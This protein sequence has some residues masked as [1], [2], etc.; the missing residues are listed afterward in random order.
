[1]KF[2]LSFIGLIALILVV[3]S[4]LF[5]LEDDLYI[6]G[7]NQ[8]EFVY[9]STED[10]LK[11][12]FEEEFKFDLSYGDFRFGMEFEGYFPRYNKFNPIYELNSDDIQSR[13]RSRFVEYQT[14]NF[15]A[16]GGTFDAVFGSGLVLHAY[17]NKLMYEDNRLEGLY[18][19][20]DFKNSHIKALYST[21]VSQ[22]YSD[23]HDIVSGININFNLLSNLTLGSS[24]LSERYY[25]DGP[26]YE[27]NER[28]VLSGDINL[29]N[30]IF[31]WKTEVAGSKKIHTVS[32]NNVEGHAVYSNLNLYLGKFT[33]TSAYKNYENFDDRF[34][35][36]PTVNYSEEPL[37]E[38]GDYSLVGRDEEGIMGKVRFIPNYNN[39][40]VV[41]YSEGWSSD[42]D[43]RQSDLH[44]A[45][46]RDFESFYLSLEFNHLEMI[47]DNN[48]HWKKEVTPKA[49]VD[50][51]LG[52]NPVLL[53][54]EYEI[55]ETD[56]AG[57][58]ETRYTP[59]L[60]AELG[61][62]S[63]SLSL[64]ASTRYK[65]DESII[66]SSPRVGMELFAPIWSHTNVKFFLG[67]EKG[68]K[69]CR[70]GVCNYQSPFSGVRLTLTTR[71]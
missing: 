46:N 26:E 68:G 59:M 51:L 38:V 49:S 14:D 67:E 25:V 41:N 61:Y 70:N 35:E 31:G 29:S 21:A 43:V 55:K 27:Y 56:I 52:E 13:W 19:K 2:K 24:F 53:K 33:I 62:N 32:G 71:F 54:A 36:P 34:S 30:D 63:Y 8:S 42:F 44:T 47:N 57:E 10:S 12:Y 58:Q 22:N 66:D 50:F 60:Q 11:S 39:E 1:M 37:A 3:W 17:D 69:V 20:I 16:R 18:T 6:S 64:F 15:L 7:M 4:N 40:F 45:Y 48:Q 65:K 5:A 9:K 23:K 28:N